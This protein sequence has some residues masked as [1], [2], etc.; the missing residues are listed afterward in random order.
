MVSTIITHDEIVSKVFNNNIVLV[1]SDKKEKILFAKGIGFGKKSGTVIPKGTEIDK[2]FIIEEE[3]NKNNFYSAMGKI[4]TDFFG[5]CEEAI[6]DISEILGGDL[7]EKIHTSLTDHLFLT[8]KRLKSNEEIDNPFL[9]EIQTLYK[10]EYNLA[11]I[12]AK[13]VEDY[14]K[15][16]IPEGEIAFIALHIHSAINNK[17]DFSALKTSYIGST[18]VEYLEK[19]LNIKIDRK[20]LDCARLYTHIKFAI[21]RILE[22]RPVNNELNKVIKNTYK[23][24]Y[25]IAQ[26]IV[27]IIGNEINVEIQDD[28]ISFLAIHVERFRN[29][30]KY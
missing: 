25:K 13:K 17:K 26:E 9:I 12:V 3:E 18:V 11:E 6:Y 30:L 21:Q 23:E 7:D 19:R 28:E 8:V 14:S 2:V 1:N 15:V 27:K 16:K 10:R 20:S 22:N 4:D 24:S 5:I 29:S